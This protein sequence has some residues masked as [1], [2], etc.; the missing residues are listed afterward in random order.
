[1][2]EHETDFTVPR[3]QTAHVGTVEA[4]M[5]AGL[6][7]QPGDNPQQRGFPG[8]GRPQQRDHLTRR[9]IQRDIVQHLGATKRLL[10]IGNLN[11]HDVPPAARVFPDSPDAT[12]TYSLKTG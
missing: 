1:M 12:A 6:M 4:N 8:T 11:A 9:N 7:L 2:L 10:N 3:V 5:P